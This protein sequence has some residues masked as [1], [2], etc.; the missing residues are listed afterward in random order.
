[1]IVEHETATVRRMMRMMSES[2]EPLA[3]Q[4]LAINPYHP[5]IKNL[6]SLRISHPDFAVLI[7]EQIYDNALI[8]AGLLDDPRS[9]L[10]RLNALLEKSSSLSSVVTASSETVPSAAASTTVE[11]SSSSSSSSSASPENTTQ[12]S[13]SSASPSSSRSSSSSSSSPS[14]PV[15]EV[16]HEGSEEKTNNIK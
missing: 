11:S 4:K 7:A 2:V 13:S 6:N 8:A 15:V 3:K 12:S 5:I 10:Q 16:V 1:M 9:M 14:D